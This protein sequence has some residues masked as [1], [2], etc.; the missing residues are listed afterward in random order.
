MCSS[1]F[2][3]SFPTSWRTAGN[4]LTRAW[5]SR[6]T[7]S[8][9]QREKVQQQDDER[10]HEESGQA[11]CHLICLT[12]RI[13]NMEQSQCRFSWFNVPRSASVAERLQCMPQGHT[14]ASVAG[15][16]PAG[17]LCCPLSLPI[18][19]PPLPVTIQ[20]RY[21]KCSPCQ[22]R[23]FCVQV[24]MFWTY[25]DAVL[26]A[27]GIVAFPEVCGWALALH[28]PPAQLLL[29]LL[30]FGQLLP[31]SR[32]LI[33]HIAAQQ[34]GHLRWDTERFFSIKKFYTCNYSL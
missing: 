3:A 34:A 18:S 20:Q 6:G 16:I 19:Y 27:G 12:D 14:A 21:P 15:S 13:V 5:S 8:P 32:T 31:Q 7:F 24:C 2:A 30:G 23:G 26:F 9:C 17:D 10:L 22:R 28:F 11:L 1:N 29:Q 25:C 4:S 33:A